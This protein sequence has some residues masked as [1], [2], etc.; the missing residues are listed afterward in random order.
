[1]ACGQE[2]LAVLREQCVVFAVYA[3]QH[4]QLAGFLQ[5]GQDFWLAE[6]AVVGH[7]KL[8]AGYAARNQSWQ[9]G[10]NIGGYVV[11]HTMKAVVNNRLATGQLVVDIYLMLQIAAHGA[12]G[13]VVDDGCGA[14]AGS[15]YGASEKAVGGSGFAH[16]QI[17]VGVHVYA[18]G[19][20]QQA[21]CVNHRLAGSSF[22]RGCHFGD[23]LAGYSNVCPRGFI[24]SY[25][26]S[27]CY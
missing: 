4:A 24:G 25:N 3:D 11:C 5:Q 7:V 15:G 22:Q 12:K 8:Q 27:I 9:L 13:H 16:Q 10:Q 26:C 18:T 19:Q 14:T 2:A 21:S 20:N 23:N 6:A 1:L 17:H